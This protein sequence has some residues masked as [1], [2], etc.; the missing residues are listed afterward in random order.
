MIRHVTALLICTIMGFLTT[1]QAH[2]VRPGYL[3]ITESQSGQ[4]DVLWKVP[5]RGD[6]VL[7]IEPSF[8]SS[9]KQVVPPSVRMV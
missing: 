9:C 1:V 6:L 4:Y 5:A 2:E 7:S 3:Y 8:S